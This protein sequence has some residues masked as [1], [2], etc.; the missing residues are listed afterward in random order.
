MARRFF[1][2]R[3]ARALKHPQ[4]GAEHILLGLLI[5]GDG[6]AAR[7]LRGLGVQTEQT[8]EALLNHLDQSSGA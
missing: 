6:V 4:V 5:E 1:A 2:A 8:R 3:E 7:I